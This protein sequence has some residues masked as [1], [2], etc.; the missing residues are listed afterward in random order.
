MDEN[1]NTDWK[2][3]PV[4]KDSPAAAREK[5]ELD[6]YRASSAA[7]TACAKAIKDIIKENWTGIGLKEGCAQQTMNTFGPDRLAFVLANTVQLR[8]YDT[9]F[10]RDTRAWAQMVLAGAEEIIPEE[11]RI[12]WEILNP[13]LRKN[14]AKRADT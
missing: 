8:A 12:G 2:A 4:Y 11:K 3:I 13:S 6:A 9:R 7:N 10:N 1:K 5:N 14:C